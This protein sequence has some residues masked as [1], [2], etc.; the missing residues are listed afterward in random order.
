MM[1]KCFS[2]FLL[3]LSLLWPFSTQAAVFIE[4]LEDVP[5]MDGLKQIPKDTLSFGNEEGRLVEVYLSG[6]KVGFKN[7]AKFYQETLPQLGWTFQGQR[8]DTLIFYREGEALD[9]YKE[10]TKPMIVRITVKNQ[11]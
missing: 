2:L 10:S 1:K 8:D 3:S 11:M 9:I 4:G 6:A 7:V 5:L